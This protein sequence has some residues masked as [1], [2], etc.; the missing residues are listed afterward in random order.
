MLQTNMVKDLRK[1]KERIKIRK[2]MLIFGTKDMKRKL[3]ER[4]NRSKLMKW[5]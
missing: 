4:N 2:S 1:Q 3:Y 5:R